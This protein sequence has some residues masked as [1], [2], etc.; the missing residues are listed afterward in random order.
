MA[1]NESKP[2]R[3]RSRPNVYS[4]VHRTG[5]VSCVVNLGL[6][7]GKRERQCFK[8][9]AEAATCADLKRTERQNQG[10]AA[11]AL[12]QAIKVDA[13]KASSILT[14]HDVSLEETARRS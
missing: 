8:T 4:R 12:P 6:I 5:Q 9:K 7:S 2:K 11:L 1:L 13:A 3:K 10:T 14:P